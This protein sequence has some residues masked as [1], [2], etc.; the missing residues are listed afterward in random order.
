M[1]CSEL[2]FVLSPQ[3]SS[4]PLLPTTEDYNPGYSGGSGRTPVMPFLVKLTK[5]LSEVE[6]YSADV[7]RWE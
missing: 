2:L 3:S 4:S 1:K 7:L 6:S 5:L